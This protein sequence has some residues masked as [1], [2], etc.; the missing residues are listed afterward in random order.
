MKSNAI[1]FW[2][3]ALIVLCYI[4]PL[5]FDRSDGTGEILWLVYLV[6]VLII[7]YYSGLKGG[8][9][10]ASL[11]TLLHLIW[12]L[13]E[14]FLDSDNFNYH[15]FFVFLLVNAVV[16]VVAVLLGAMITQIKQK[17]NELEQNNLEL[18][19]ALDTINEGFM[20]LDKNL[21]I[22][23]LNKMAMEVAGFHKTELIGRKITEIKELDLPPLFLENCVKAWDSEQPA[24]FELHS[25]ISQK[26]TE[27]SIYPSDNR[28]T[29]TFK[30]ITDRIQTN[31]VLRSSMEIF[32]KAFV[33]SPIP[34]ALSRLVNGEFVDVNKSFEVLT[35]YSKE[36]VVGKPTV[37]LPLDL[38][39]HIELSNRIKKDGSVRNIETQ[40]TTKTG[41]IKTGLLSFEV[42]NLGDEEYLLG[43][44]SDITDLKK[45]QSEMTR[46]DRLNLVG[47]MAAGLGH[48]IRNPLTTVRGFLQ[49]LG[50]DNHFASA[51]EHFDLMISEL[52]QANAIISEFLS[53]AKTKPTEL[54]QANLNQLI[55]RL[56][57]L[58]EADAA[59]K[60][61][62]ILLDL[63]DT[64]DV[65]VDA[66]EI[67]QLILNLVRNGLEAMTSGGALTIKTRNE[68]NKVV[69]AI[70]DQGSGISKEI[71]DRLGTPF[72]STK[73]TGTG[74]G[75]AVCYGIAGRHNASIEVETGSKGTTFYV[76]FQYLSLVGAT[77]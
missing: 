51:K 68:D 44:C 46:L 16:F 53:L 6:P 35:S 55:E 47:V 9:I 18:R 13:K 32:K 62:R 58:V 76:K 63:H 10:T 50:G 26:W 66:R 48:E 2:Y 33:V 34:M 11:G 61:K 64:P 45:F 43:A 21:N 42:V 74:L 22:T 28:L 36:E 40:W 1:P 52:D 60:D 15:N 8:I 67:R 38:R 71:M 37:N 30:D 24:T 19:T 4:L 12:E 17:D 39:K 69:L 23:Y 29:L 31:A 73:D 70:Q 27:V 14:L 72:L 7:T 75:L 3:K 25:K 56:Y 57:P 49:F 20:S 41:E 59:C 54:V 65:T 5:I 77:A